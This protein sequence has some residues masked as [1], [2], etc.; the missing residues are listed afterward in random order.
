M[1]ST[2]S[3]RPIGLIFAAIILGFFALGAAACG[4]ATL[5]V[6]TNF[7]Q[8][9][10]PTAPG[11]PPLSPDLLKYTLA[12]VALIEL[13]IAA[14]GIFT[15]VGLL[16]LK[17]WARYS[18]LVIG[19][20]LALFGIASAAGLALLPAIMAQTPQAQGAAL[21]PHLMQGLLLALGLF[22]TG[23]AA[24]GVWWLVYFNLRTVKAY[25]L[26]GFAAPYYPPPFPTAAS[27]ATPGGL[28]AM[29]VPPPLPGQALPAGRFAGV[30]TSIKVIACFFLL[31]GLITAV[32]IFLPFP[33]FLAGIYFSGM[34]AHLLYLVYAV[35]TLLIGFGLLRL[36][37]RA[38][39]GVYALV[40][41]AVVNSIV[42]LTPWG[43][44]RFTVYNHLLQQRMHLPP[45]PA[46]FDTAS[47]VFIS[48]GLILAVS[49]YGVLLYLIE[50]H[51]AAFRNSPPA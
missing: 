3:H 27:L 34:G 11:T 45:T 35:W 18:I 47:P 4:A 6:A 38:R 24:V 9:A 19:G 20:L 5:L 15:I 10:L 50:R 8:H 41:L 39:F 22:Y 7:S 14:W 12:G 31:G 36:D 37:N 48:L 13:L 32:F 42:T 33:A 30:P 40:G 2:R 49:F 26:P 43:R 25:F 21:P 51:R 16:R 29:Q 17:S 28:D 1:N 46:A 44:G 23:V